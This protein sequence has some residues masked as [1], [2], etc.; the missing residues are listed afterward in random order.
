VANTRYWLRDEI[1]LIQ[2][3]NKAVAAEDFSVMETESQYR[4]HGHAEL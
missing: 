3:Y 4:P 1:A 2:P